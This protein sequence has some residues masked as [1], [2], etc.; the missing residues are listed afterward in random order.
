MFLDAYKEIIRTK[1]RSKKFSDFIMDICSW[2]PL[3]MYETPSGI[4]VYPG[5]TRHAPTVSGDAF[6]ENRGDIITRKLDTSRDFFE[7]FGELFQSVSLP[8]FHHYYGVENSAYS[9]HVSSTSSA[10]SSFH[11][12]GDCEWVM[13]SLST[14]IHATNIYNST[15]SW[16]YSENIYQSLGIIG[17]TSV[18]Y[19]KYI[20]DS[21]DIWFSTDLIGCQECISCHDM[22]NTSYAIDNITYPKEIYLTKKK[23][24]LKDTTSYDARYQTLRSIGKS[25]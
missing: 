10:Y 8:G 12:T 15:M 18:H 21:R 23:E 5:N 14:K 24:L 3:R 16:M 7:Q 20:Q 25:R 1:H 6:E 13:Y 17:S 9:N 22:T 2:Y 19:S 4:G 11:V